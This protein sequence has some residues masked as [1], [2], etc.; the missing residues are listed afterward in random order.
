MLNLN[1]Y[2]TNSWTFCHGLDFGGN[3]V[4]G[5]L[6][7]KQAFSDENIGIGKDYCKFW[8]MRHESPIS[9]CQVDLAEQNLDCSEIEDV[10]SLGCHFSS[11][12]DKY[13]SVTV[14]FPKDYEPIEV[15]DF[16][17]GES[18]DFFKVRKNICITI[19]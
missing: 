7:I 4:E 9:K 16:G 8:I 6:D 11:V 13:S 2:I 10:E 12:S 15:E 17:E 18:A 14:Q 5:D 19:I 3:I 1:R